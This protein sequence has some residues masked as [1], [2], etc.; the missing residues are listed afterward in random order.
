MSY[1]AGFWICNKAVFGRKRPGVAA[2]GLEACL[3]RVADLPTSHI[4]AT[5]PDV[6]H[7]FNIAGD[8]AHIS[9]KLHN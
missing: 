4:V 8:Y 3:R 5:S 6:L 1:A 9:L 2:I 7:S